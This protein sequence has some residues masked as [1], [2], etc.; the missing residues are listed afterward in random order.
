MRPVLKCPSEIA[1][2]GKILMCLKERKQDEERLR[3]LTQFDAYSLVRP[4]NGLLSVAATW[5][6]LQ[7]MGQ[8]SEY[9][10]YMA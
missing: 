10:D 6:C 7:S 1:T 4:N 9:V 8:Y 3:D 5:L 2:N